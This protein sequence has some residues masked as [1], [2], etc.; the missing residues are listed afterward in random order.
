LDAST[1]QKA[2]DITTSVANR[3]LQKAATSRM[4]S[5]ASTLFSL[6]VSVLKIALNCGA[7]RY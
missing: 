4:L 7:Q 6:I 5:P 3:S 2:A 1:K